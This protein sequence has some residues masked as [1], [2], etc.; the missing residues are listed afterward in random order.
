MGRGWSSIVPGKRAEG[1]R[2]K[3]VVV[4]GRGPLILH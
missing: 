4:N 1:E 3:G 2:I